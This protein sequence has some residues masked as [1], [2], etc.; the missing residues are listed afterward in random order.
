[1]PLCFYALMPLC[2][3]GAFRAFRAFRA[4]GKG[5]QSKEGEAIDHALCQMH[6][7]TPL[8]YYNFRDQGHLKGDNLYL[9]TRVIVPDKR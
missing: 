8:G 2:P 3:V 5:G 4:F 1:M 6:D 9:C 7:C